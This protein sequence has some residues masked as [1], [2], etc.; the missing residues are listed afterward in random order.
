MGECDRIHLGDLALCHGFVEQ[1]LRNRHDVMTVR[2]NHTLGRPVVREVAAEGRG[3]RLDSLIGCL[4][5]GAEA[6]EGRVIEIERSDCLAADPVQ[7]TIVITNSSL[8]GAIP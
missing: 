2:A 8:L 6:S 7:T 4:Q 1:C 5:I 3:R